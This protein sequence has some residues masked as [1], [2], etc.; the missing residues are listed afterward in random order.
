MSPKK[1]MNLLGSCGVAI[2]RKT[3]SAEGKP[4]Q[5]YLS[6]LISIAILIHIKMKKPMAAKR[7]NPIFL[8]LPLYIDINVPKTNSIIRFGAPN[9]IANKINT[10]DNN[11]SF[12]L[13]DF[14][15]KHNIIDAT[16][17]R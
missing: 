10:P 12:P 7:I 5:R 9:I 13:K 6:V 17:I 4:I 8:V 15:R 14:K 2:A 11:P 1:F 3:K 16:N